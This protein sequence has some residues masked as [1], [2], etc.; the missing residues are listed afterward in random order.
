[1]KRILHFTLL[2]TFCLAATAHAQNLALGQW[3]VHLPFNKVKSVAEAGNKIYCA[4]ERGLFY[5]DR[6]D[7]TVNGLSKIDGLSEL[8][9][10]NLA[11][12]A[13][14]NTL[15]IA[16]S[17][18][19]IDLIKNNKIINIPDIKRKNLTGDKS[20]YNIEVRGNLAYLSCGFGIVV[21]DLD[22][23]EI[24]DTY[25]IGPLG[26]SIKVFD[27]AFYGSDIYAATESGIFRAFE[28]DP[29]LADYSVWTKVV[30]DLGNLGDFNQIEFFNNKLIANYAKPNA[31]SANSLDDFYIYDGI[32]W[33]SPPPPP[34]VNASAKN[35]TFRNSHG[36]LLITNN[37][38][39]RI[40][41]SNFNQVQYIDNAIYQDPLPRD[42]ITDAQGVIWLADNEQ[43]LVRFTSTLIPQYIYPDGPLSEL[44]SASSVVHKRL[45]ITHGTR[46]AGWF[47]FYT[48][49]NF[50]S[51]IQGDW[52][53]YN[54]KTLPNSGFNID[55]YYDNMSL[56]IDPSDPDH[57]F[58][59][60]KVQG[61][62]EMQNGLPIAAYRETN[63]TLQVGIGNPTQ[64][65]VVGM[66]FDQSG[67]L[68]VLN[69]LAAKPLSALSPDGTWRAF[70][71]P[72]IP[73][74]PLLGDLTV[75]SYGQ[76]WINVI[77]NNAPLGT[78]LAVFSDN[79]T[80]DD[81]TDDAA[82]FFSTGIGKGNLPSTDIR[83]ITEDHD[84]EIWLGTGKG[85]A[86]IY[87]PAS[88][89]TSQ[90]YDAQQILIKQDGINQY[91]LESEVVTAIA[92]DGA[93]RKWI[94]T[95]SGG[96]FLMSPDGTEQI[97]NF[98]ELNSPLL[99]NYIL[100][101]SIDQE[102]GD[103]YFGTNKGLISYRG[104]AI[105]GTGG[106]S[107]ILVYPNPVR[108]AYDG[109]IAIRGL[110]PNGSVK[111]TDVSGNIV[112]ET[113]SNGALA[114]WNGKNFN[115]EKVHTGVYLVFSSDDDGSNTCVTKL[116]FIN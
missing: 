64:C 88:V 26:S 1:M 115:G 44:V 69:S 45:W 95:E 71:I 113:K 116:L 55:S 7:N 70:S 54:N 9:V 41:D 78:G 31:A 20:I 34:F 35:Y 39:V 98:N 107:D 112:Y 91:L 51:F 104:D 27:I 101:I 3:K 21:I 74:A 108:P 76:K 109:P 36:Q 13:D 59:G 16:Y 43:G 75:D 77:G 37:Y 62:L 103:V 24:R 23:T 111:I 15:I 105:E 97:R 47:N 63:S 102:T 60:S 90:N 5:Y 96:V 33:T 49:G 99:S 57:V 114:T 73:G 46:T 52:K 68:W 38:S 4:S 83:A 25:I 12:S 67:N 66:N 61:L 80:L 72:G 29:N 89:L 22:K 40:Y 56:A 8:T 28:N 86:V 18:A 6:N 10:N 53:T 50:S 92:V 48:P 106:C 11:W 2:I 14:F 19:N 87:S 100:T 58:I 81:K 42:A 84:N 32:S 94:G 17:N 79:G 110:V 93:N 85:V 30:D 82:R 65:Q